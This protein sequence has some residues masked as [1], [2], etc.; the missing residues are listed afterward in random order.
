MSTTHDEAPYYH[1]RVRKLS[2]WAHAA[3]FAP[4]PP[5]PPPPQSLSHRTNGGS[6][7]AAG[8]C[9]EQR[10]DQIIVKREMAMY[11]PDGMEK[12]RLMGE[13]KKLEMR[14]RDS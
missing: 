11:L 3:S 9:G 8:L 1:N 12:A 6:S 4:A 7:S 2:Q 5:P 14:G 10:R 13:I